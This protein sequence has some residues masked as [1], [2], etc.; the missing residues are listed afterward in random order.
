MNS[1]SLKV[2]IPS[3]GSG[4]GDRVADQAMPK[5]LDVSIPSRGSGKGDQVPPDGGGVTPPKEFQSPLG[6]VVKETLPGQK[7]PGKD[8]RFQSPLGEVVKET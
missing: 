8:L 5:E 6:E 3:R 1:N 4:K 7:D 2:S